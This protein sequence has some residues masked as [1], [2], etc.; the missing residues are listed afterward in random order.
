MA[1]KPCREC[2]TK[3]SDSAKRCPHCRSDMPFGFLYAIAMQIWLVIILGLMAFGG[4]AVCA[5]GL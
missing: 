1:L 2:G 4:F 5:Y 3:I